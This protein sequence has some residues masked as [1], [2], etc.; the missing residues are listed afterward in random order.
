MAPRA[1]IVIVIVGAG[2][3]RNFELQNHPCFDP[4]AHDSLGLQMAREA[5]TAEG[6]NPAATLA[7]ASPWL[8]TAA[9]LGVG[10]H[11][12]TRLS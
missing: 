8:A 5:L 10:T 3:G 1:S 6:K 11:T 7:L 9:E 12:L 2:W 4:V